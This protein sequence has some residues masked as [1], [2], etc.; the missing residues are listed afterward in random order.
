[1][2][3]LEGGELRDSEDSAMAVLST[4]NS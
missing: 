4:I 2:L 1:L 3:K